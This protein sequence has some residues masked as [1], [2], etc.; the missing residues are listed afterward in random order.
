[1]LKGSDRE[2]EYELKNRV[3]V[4]GIVLTRRGF[5]GPFILVPSIP[6]NSAAWISDDG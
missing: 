6:S 4:N 1:M 5:D 2:E 3:C